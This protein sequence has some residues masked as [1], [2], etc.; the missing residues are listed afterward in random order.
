MELWQMDGIATMRKEPQVPEPFR[1]TGTE[2][3]HQ[4]D[5]TRGAPDDGLDGFAKLPFPSRVPEFFSYPL[6][7]KTQGQDLAVIGD[8]PRATHSSSADRVM[9]LPE[10]LVDS[11]PSFQ[12]SESVP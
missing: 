3:S 10:V 5:L 6:V 8:Y 12:Q 4:T 2:T 11:R 1:D 7:A 9:L